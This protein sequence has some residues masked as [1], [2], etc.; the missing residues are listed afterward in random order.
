[1][2]NSLLNIYKA[3][4]DKYKSENAIF[5]FKIMQYE[6]KKIPLDFK[7]EY[8]IMM[9]NTFNKALEDETIKEQGDLTKAKQLI[10]IINKPQAIP[11]IDDII[12]YLEHKIND[13]EKK[14]KIFY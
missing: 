3:E 7:E 2:N 14:R 10:D 13:I 1:M 4:L 6:N 8:Q 5:K 9:E 12:L 11:Y